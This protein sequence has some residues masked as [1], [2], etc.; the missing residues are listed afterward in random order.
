MPQLILQERARENEPE[1]LSEDDVAEML[2]LAERLRRQNGG[3]LDESAI[4]AVAEATGAPLD[5][6]RLAVRLR[7]ERRRKNLASSLRAQFFT[8]EPDTRRYV[9]SGMLATAGAFMTV[10]D[11]RVTQLTE[12]FNEANYGIFSM[13]ALIVFAL[14]LYNIAIARSPKVAAVGGSILTGT[15]FLARS[16]FGLLMM[17]KMNVAPGLLFPVV[18]LGAGMGYALNRMITMNRAK[19]GL[20][21][22]VQE[23]QELLAQLHSLREQLHSGEQSLAF[24]CVDVVGSTRMKDNA[25]PLA[26]EFTFNEFFQYIE[27]ITKK[28]GGRVHST[29]GDGAI[30]AFDHAEQA[31]RAAK[32]MQGEI[33]ELNLMRNK[34]DTPLAIRCGVHTG[35]VISPDATDVRSITISQVIDI[36]AHLEAIAP[37]GGVAVSGPAAEEM[38]MDLSSLGMLTEVDGIP[39]GIWQPK[40]ALASIGQRPPPVPN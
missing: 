17:V 26:V 1:E 11:A 32:N 20:R 27:R 22:P 19:L 13:L 21:D 18:A 25:D 37:P 5:Y 14:A 33:L 2:A 16:I 28:H 3:S 40:T 35:K 6:V 39:A 36:A 10:L 15:F 30:C 7:A 4:Q 31:F 8:L 34:L 9:S 23:R 12:F 24:L 38:D 29:A